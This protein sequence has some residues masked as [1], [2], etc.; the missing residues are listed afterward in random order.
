MI[1]WKM[2]LVDTC[3]RAISCFVSTRGQT[4]YRAPQLKRLQKDIAVEA[5]HMFIPV[6]GTFRCPPDM[7]EVYMQLMLKRW[8]VQVAF[9][10]HCPSIWGSWVCLKMARPR[11]LLVY[12]M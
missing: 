4:W 11:N 12:T 7:L 1:R 6:S 9:F 3:F 10:V 5:V 2:D 8:K